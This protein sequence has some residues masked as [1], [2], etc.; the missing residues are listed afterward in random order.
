MMSHTVR[1]LIR[2]IQTEVRESQDLQPDRAA[3]LLLRLS[4]LYGNVLDEL[5]AADI[6]YNDVLLEA[7]Q[8]EG[9]ANKAKL[10]AQA[11]EQYGRWRAAHDT[12]KLT[13][14]LTRT[15]KAFLRVKQ[16]EMRLAR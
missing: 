4:A 3:E 1:S 6:A 2:E 13:L 11:S 5:R 15:L 16:E 10:R 9:A 14:E 12:E 8:R 7:M